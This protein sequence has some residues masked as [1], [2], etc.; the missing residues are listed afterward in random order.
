M[1]TYQCRILAEDDGTAWEQGL[2]GKPSPRCV[3][4]MS[5]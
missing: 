1:S 4:L 2:N 3:L 5:Y